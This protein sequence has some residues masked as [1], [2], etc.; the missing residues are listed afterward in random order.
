MNLEN[1]DGYIVQ[2]FTEEGWK[3]YPVLT[4]SDFNAARVFIQ[5][6]AEL[7]KFKTRIIGEIMIHYP[8]EQI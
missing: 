3:T 6:N 2:K 7:K 5:K 1:F 4:F 8:E